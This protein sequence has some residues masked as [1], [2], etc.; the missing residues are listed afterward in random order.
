LFG[1]QPMIIRIRGNRN[2]NI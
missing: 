1:T 2:E